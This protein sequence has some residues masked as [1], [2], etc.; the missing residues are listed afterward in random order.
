MNILSR[1]GSKASAIAAI[2][3]A[4]VALVGFNLFAAQQLAPWRA[5][6]TQERLFTISKA[7][8]DVLNRLDEPITLRLYFSKALAERAP[9]YAEYGERVKALLRQYAGLSH[10]RLRVEVIDPEPFSA[11]EDKAIAAGLTAI[12]LG[13]GQSAYFG[14]AGENSTDQTGVI[15]FLDAGRASFLEYDL[16]KLVHKLN[17]PRKKVIGVLTSLPMFGGYTPRGGKKPDWGVI[18]QM[19]DFYKVLP[20]ETSNDHI[21]A[22]VDVLLIVSPVKLPEKMARAVD[23]FALSGKPVVVYADPWNE[24][25]AVDRQ[26]VSQSEL[27]ADDPLVK[28]LK[29]WGVG[30]STG[31]VVGDITFARRVIF[32]AGGRR[33]AASYLVWLDMDKRAFAAAKDPAFANV[34]KMIVGSAGALEKLKDAKTAF[35]PL[36]RTSPKAMLMSTDNMASPNPLEL[37]AAY[38]PGGAPLVMAA[39]VSGEAKS[40]FAGDKPRDGGKPKDGGKSGGDKSGGKA[41]SGGEK[42]ATP[43][44]GK[45]NVVVFADSDTLSD[46]FWAE[47]RRLSQTETMIIPA[48]GNATFLLNI[49]EQM[50]G[51][52]AL[53]GL[54]GRTLVERPFEK[55]VAIQKAAEARFRQRERELKSKLDEARK[56]LAG[57]TARVK[58]GKVVISEKDS[59]LI[60]SVR[61][62][63]LKLR[64]KLRDVQRALRRDIENLGFWLK[65][66]NIA[67]VA[68]F[69]ALIAFIV[70]LARRARARR[71]RLNVREGA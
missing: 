38:K 32:S 68:L 23:A 42:T 46:R 11:D 25:A 35:S 13:D 12:P 30:I 4:A 22:T 60:I 37:L 3:L 15:P 50:S 39:R 36:V 58:N 1:S 69:V 6:F 62:E 53:S 14:V 48:A 59:E 26:L 70:A 66:I 63:I 28:L 65:V 41:K 17:N 52:S 29:A 67:G 64:R 34:S 2:A 43:E 5:D 49:L 21:P 27:K 55:V 24:A 18:L 19:R 71:A 51:G 61:A 16:T 9:F 31:K 47:R 8:R 44:S 7:T 20:V 33:Q 45:V 10:G 57:I 56:R 54:R 40:A